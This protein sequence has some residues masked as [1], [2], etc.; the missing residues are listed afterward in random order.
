MFKQFKKQIAQ[1]MASL[2][3]E[4]RMNISWEDYFWGDGEVERYCLP[5]K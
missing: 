3:E 5:I 4:T 1:L 2:V